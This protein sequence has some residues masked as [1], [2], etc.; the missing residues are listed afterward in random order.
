MTRKIPRACGNPKC[1]V[2]TGI[3][4]GLTFGSG[5]LDVHGFW[6]NPCRL[7]ARA[8]EKDHPGKKAW[9]Y[10]KED[11]QDS[12]PI[13]MKDV[14]GQMGRLATEIHGE[15]GNTRNALSPREKKIFDGIKQK[16]EQHTNEKEE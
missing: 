16:Q 13:T 11:L 2:S 14:E 15:M 5:D 7:C 1:G 12:N 3:H 10:R 6:E 4:R 8:Y 9:P